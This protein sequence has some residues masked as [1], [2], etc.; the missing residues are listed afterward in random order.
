MVEQLIRNKVKRQ[1]TDSQKRYAIDRTHRRFILRIYKSPYKPIS[2]IE[3]MKRQFTKEE[4]H[5]ATNHNKRC[6]ITGIRIMQIE[7]IMR[8][9]QTHQTGKNK[10]DNI[11]C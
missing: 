2:K 8:L 10:S 9:F 4:T 11:K 1:A 3:K 7:M 6:S 5:V